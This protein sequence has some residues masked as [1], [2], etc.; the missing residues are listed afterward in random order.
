MPVAMTIAAFQPKL[1][2]N[3]GF[4][5]HTLFR[6]F[7]PVGVSDMVTRR[8]CLFS[9]ESFLNQLPLRREVNPYIRP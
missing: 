5:A 3:G 2:V 9:L 6:F 7:A 4:A 8:V 1:A